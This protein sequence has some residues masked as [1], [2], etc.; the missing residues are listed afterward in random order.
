MS[1]IEALIDKGGRRA[2][3]DRRS[4]TYS[5]HIPERRN[6][7]DRRTGEDRRYKVPDSRF[8]A[9]RRARQ[10]IETTGKAAFV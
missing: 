9:D 2:S 3:L 7:R 4:F 10:G 6:G 1:G 5:A 8:F